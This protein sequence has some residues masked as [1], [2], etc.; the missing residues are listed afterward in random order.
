MSDEYEIFEIWVE[1]NRDS[2]GSGQEVEVPLKNL[3]TLAKINVLA[4]IAEEESKNGV[5]LRVVNDM[6]EKRGALFINIIKELDE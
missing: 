2:I 4:T 6:G 3:E 5:P 1:E